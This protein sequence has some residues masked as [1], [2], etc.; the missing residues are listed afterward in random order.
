MAFGNDALSQQFA[1]APGMHVAAPQPLASD[2]GTAFGRQTAGA[3]GIQPASASNYG[4]KRLTAWA[5]PTG[6]P[7][8]G[9]NIGSF[10]NFDA[11]QQQQPVEVR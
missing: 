3:S 2:T 7:L 11:P 8:G 5:S 4:L 10:I 9:T 6:A 1:A